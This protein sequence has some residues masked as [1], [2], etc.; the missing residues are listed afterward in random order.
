[1]AVEDPIRCH[2]CG[3]SGFDEM[4]RAKPVKVRCKCGAQVWI[5]GR[6]TSIKVD[7]TDAQEVSDVTL[8]LTEQAAARREAA[9]LRSPWFSGLFY[10][11]VLVIVIALLL[12]VG[13]VL[14]GWA[15]P[16]VI[17]G[18]ILLVSVV[19]AFQMRQ[20]DKLSERGFL[21]LMADVFR[22]LPLLL[23]R[24]DPADPNGH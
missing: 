12:V 13:S 22:R 21:R 6:T 4:Q 19:G 15:L 8:R 18:A 7:G 1:M 16:V 10:I 9:K 11:A 24:R 2:L 23:P 5:R 17:V 14:P 20:D 3:G